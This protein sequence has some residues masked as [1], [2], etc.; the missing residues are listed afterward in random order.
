MTSAFEKYL[1]TELA[2]ELLAIIPPEALLSPRSTVDPKHRGKVPGHYNS[3]T[4]T[5]SGRT[6]WPEGFATEAMIREWSKYPDPNIGIR[7]KYFPVI[8][9]DINLDWLIRDLLSLAEQHLGPAP[10]RGRNDSPRVMMLY[11]L[12]EG[13]EPIRSWPLKFTLPET[14][15]IQHAVEI[16]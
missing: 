1:G 7:T 9:F 12:A 6:D 11:R 16:L 13:A 2:A 8:D 10:V 5:W 3:A 15:N 14:G 4:G